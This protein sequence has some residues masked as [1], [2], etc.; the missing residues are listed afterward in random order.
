MNKPPSNDVESIDWLACPF[1]G[2]PFD[3]LYLNEFKGLD[4]TYEEY[5]CQ[6][7]RLKTWIHTKGTLKKW[8]NTR[9]G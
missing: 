5:E 1:C 4:K 7:C 3:K 2:E 6:G 8:W 9:V